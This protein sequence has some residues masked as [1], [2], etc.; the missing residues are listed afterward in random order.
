[1]YDR[2][3]DRANQTKLY[4]TTAK[5]RTNT[6]KK[7]DFGIDFLSN[8][9]QKKYLPP[10]RSMVVSVNNHTLFRP[11]HWKISLPEIP[12]S[13]KSLF[14]DETQMF[15]AI[16]DEP[17]LF[18][19]VFIETFSFNATSQI[20]TNYLNM[21]NLLHNNFMRN[22]IKESNHEELQF[23]FKNIQIRVE[24]LAQYSYIP[25][26][27]KMQQLFLASYRLNIIN[28]MYHK[29]SDFFQSLIV[30]LHGNPKFIQYW[31][32]A[33]LEF[34]GISRDIEFTVNVCDG[35][36]LVRRYCYIIARLIDLNHAYYHELHYHHDRAIRYL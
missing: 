6:V 24:A 17:R 8:W 14:P 22:L 25:Y 28:S 5:T 35:I 4:A 31:I 33:N 18:S 34:S 32:C 23:A 7:I 20:C 30:V 12:E 21:F 27:T 10:M 13:I 9:E 1:M 2:R 19:N 29:Y 36:Q 3:V 11:I 16:T 15:P 26:T